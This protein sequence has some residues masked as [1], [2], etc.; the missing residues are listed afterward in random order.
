[1]P[2]EEALM[3]VKS[4]EPIG[5]KGTLLWLSFSLGS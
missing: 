3:S 2:Q 4:L 1:M 5:G